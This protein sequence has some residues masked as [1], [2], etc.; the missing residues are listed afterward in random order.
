VSVIPAAIAHINYIHSHTGLST[1]VHLLLAVLCHW[2]SSRCSYALFLVARVLPGYKLWIINFLNFP[3]P[4]NPTPPFA[5]PT[6]SLNPVRGGERCK[7]PQW[8]PCILF[9]CAT[10][11][12]NEFTSIHSRY[13]DD[14]DILARHLPINITTTSPVTQEITLTFTRRKAQR[15]RVSQVSEFS[16]VILA[17][18]YSRIQFTVLMT[19]MKII[20][21]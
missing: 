11:I 7:L 17:T 1:A 4:Q 16:S 13:D 18:P 6:T 12:R 5:F 14:D 21:N 8:G 10:L 20:S 2:P 3:L 15:M 19:N 9:R